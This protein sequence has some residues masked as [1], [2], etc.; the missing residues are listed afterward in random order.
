M[1][2]GALMRRQANGTRDSRGDRR[3]LPASFIIPI[4]LVAATYGALA[5]I[6]I[7]EPKA[8][9][10]PLVAAI[11]AGLLGLIAL[12]ASIGTERASTALLVL[13]FGF[14]PLT[15]FS[16]GP[17]HLVLASALFAVAF[18]LAFPR[19]I[20]RPFRPPT[21]FVVGSV[22]FAVM[23]LLSIPMA[24][25]ALNSAVYLATAVV[26][27][28]AIP[29]AVV[30]MGPNDRQMFAMALAFG[31]GTAVSTLIGLSRNEYRNSGFTYHPVALAYTAMLALSFVPYLLAS[32][33]MRSR[34]IVVPPVALIALVGVW[35]SGSRTGLVVLAALTLIVPVMERSIRLGLLVAGGVV[36]LLPTVLTFDPKDGSTSALSR[37]LGSGGAEESDD[38]RRYTL[39]LGWEQIQESPIFGNGYSIEGTY[40]IHNIYLQVLQ[41]EGL[42]GLVGLLMMFAALVVPLRKA[43][44]PQRCLAYPALAVM[45]AGPFQ[46]N[47]S[48]HYLGLSL[49]LSLV[50]AVGVMNG[51]QPPDDHS[52]AKGLRG[53]EKPQVRV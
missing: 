12:V 18:A 15:S 40:V 38:T 23:G 25:S 36:I 24:P 10:S 5:A 11:A 7:V 13:A 42:I 21:M 44:E 3:L 30:W 20:H 51:R 32:K 2:S 9:T 8:M 39:R 47:M 4:G 26:A 50:A 43:S 14:A 31:I 41:A 35:T 19:L 46:P 37:L 29:A 17:T 49:G 1:D 6:V 27:L 52:D 33:G 34:W 53:P 48:D 45:L 22:L 16:L 28:V